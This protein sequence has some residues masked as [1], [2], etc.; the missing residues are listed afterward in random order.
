MLFRTIM[1]KESFFAMNRILLLIIVVASAFIPLL[2]LPKTYQPPVQVELLPVFVPVKSIPSALPTMETKVAGNIA[3]PENPIATKQNPNLVFSVQQ[4]LQ[5]GY[6][7]GF[8]ITLLFLVYSLIT[9]LSLFRKARSIKMDGYR[10]LIIDREIAAFSFGRLVILSQN[11]YEEHSQS[12]LAHEQAH[13]RLCHFFDLLLLEIIRIFHWFNP[14]IHWLIRDMKEIHEFQADD[15]TLTKGIDEIQ[16]KLLIIQKGVGPQMFALANSFNHCQIQKRLVMMNKE[17]PVKAWSWKVATFLPLLALLLM[18]FGRKAENEPPEGS[19][20]SSIAQVVSKDS[21]K[22]WSETDFLT[23]DGLN[24]LIK[25][26]KIPNWTEPEF[27]SI[28]N[29]GK[30]VTRKRPYFSDFNSC[31]VQIDSKS[32]IWIRNHKQQLN[33]NEFKDS[34][35]TYFDYDFANGKTKPY[36]HRC[37]VNGMEKMS[38]QCMLTLLSDLGTPASDYQRFLNTIGNTILEIRGKY[39][40]EIYKKEYPKLS[41]EQREQ[42]DILIPLIARFIKSPRLKPEPKLVQE[43]KNDSSVMFLEIRRDGY[44]INNKLYPCEDFIKRINEWK[45]IKKSNNL[46]RFTIP[47]FELSDIRNAELTKISKATGIPFVQNTTVDRQATFP[48]GI[49]AMFEWIKKNIRYSNEDT[50]HPNKKDVVVNFVVNANGNIVNVLIIKGINP[51][52]DAEILKSVS[53]MPTWKPAL[54]NGL[55]SNSDYT[56]LIPL[57]ATKGTFKL[58][59]G[60]ITPPSSSI[61]D[62]DSIVSKTIIVEKQIQNSSAENP[63]KINYSMPIVNDTTYH[64]QMPTRKSKIFKQKIKKRTDQD[65]DFLVL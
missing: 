32:Q 43:N 33:W 48:G 21:T 26:G 18:A 27:G 5:Y 6:I 19:A 25:M 37:L 53:Q 39:S 52:L 63:S 1:R 41:S 58:S 30:W 16:Y 2:Y 49:D 7:A 13:I 54:K 31:F 4:L 60:N 15:Y 10:L 35:R 42:I 51:E 3:V 17:K 29:N 64:E 34:I 23:L 24:Q 46:F 11:D 65:K 55:P 61:L 44:Y 38:P 14:F 56:L 8:L 59:M 57:N 62:K 9:I 22:Q 50:I 45:N 20:L 28:E 40:L 12:M 36:F 47:G